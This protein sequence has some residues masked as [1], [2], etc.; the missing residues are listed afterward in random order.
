MSARIHA[1]GLSDR[2]R[3]TTETPPYIHQTYPEHVARCCEAIR[4]RHRGES[5]VQKPDGTWFIGGRD[6]PVERRVL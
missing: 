4:A 6:G 5:G 2:P 3:K 1:A